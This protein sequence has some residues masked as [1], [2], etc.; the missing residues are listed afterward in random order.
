MAHSGWW[1]QNEQRSYPFL[2]NRLGQDGSTIPKE[3]IVDL[4]VWMGPGSGFDASRDVAYL[5]RIRRSDDLFYF[6][7]AFSNL[8]GERL[9]FSRDVNDEPY[10][11]QTVELAETGG[12]DSDSGSDSIPCVLPARCRG[13]L[14]TGDLRTLRELLPSDGQ[15]EGGAALQLEPAVI[16]NLDRH[17]VTRLNVANLD[18]TRVTDEGDCPAPTWSHD[19]GSVIVVGRCL[20]GNVQLQEGY[21]AQIFQNDLDVSLEFSAE[22][23]AGAGEACQDV[24]LFDGDV[25]PAGRT[26]LDGAFRCNEVL[27]SINGL[28]GRDLSLRGRG[29]VQIEPD[30]DNNR[31]LVRVEPLEQGASDSAP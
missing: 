18:R 3:C 25:P 22:V 15:L 24:P 30:R 9:T 17:Q 26:T 27:R 6:D 4:L 28:S 10:V 29:G 14:T 21:N 13:V 5:E 8:P 23:G 16:L 2:P 1:N 19:V 11:T 12:S 7:F 20:Q 31:V